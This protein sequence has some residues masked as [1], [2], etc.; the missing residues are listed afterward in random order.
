MT[1]FTLQIKEA[2]SIRFVGRQV[3]CAWANLKVRNF[4]LLNPTECFLIP[5][6][7]EFISLQS[8]TMKIE[9]DCMPNCDNTNFF[10]QSIVRLIKMK[11]EFIIT[12]IVCLIIL[13]AISHM[14]LGGEFSMGYHRLPEVRL[15]VR[16]VSNVQKL[17]N[18][19]QNSAEAWTLV[20]HIRCA[21]WVEQMNL[22]ACD[23]HIIIYSLCR[24][25]WRIIFR[26]DYTCK[27]LNHRWPTFVCLQA[28]RCWD[29]QS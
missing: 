10:V 9:C 8:E 29:L 21:W 13:A 5:S 14:V 7:D 11:S 17:R 6:P 27:L 3:W 19:S 28:A 2:E 15:K 1:F 16:S 22:W 20:R 4:R 12:L 26:F 24:R 25:P 18:F 23:N